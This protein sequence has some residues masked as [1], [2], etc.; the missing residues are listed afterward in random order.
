[1]R[2]SYAHVEREAKPDE[3]RKVTNAD[4]DI[5]RYAMNRAVAT[6]HEVLYVILKSERSANEPRVYVVEATTVDLQLGGID[7]AFRA[8][9]LGYQEDRILDL[10]AARFV[11]GA[12]FFIFF[13]HKFQK[14]SPM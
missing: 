2:L 3:Q 8:E 1:M 12:G 13:V 11:V 14:S 7:G 10:L 9:R 6:A 4:M 5:E